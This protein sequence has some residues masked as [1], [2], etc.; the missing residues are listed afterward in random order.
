MAEIIPFRAVRFS[1]EKVRDLSLVVAPPYDVISPKQQERFWRQHPNNVIRLI[2]NNEGPDRYSRAAGYFRRWLKEGVLI[3]DGQPSIYLYQQKYLLTG[4]TEKITRGFIAL[5]KL[6]DPDTGQI[7]ATENIFSKPSADRL[8][9]LK[10]C[11]ANLGL[12]LS[13]YYDP[14]KTVTQL[15]RNKIRERPLSFLVDHEGIEHKLWQ[16]TDS[17]IIKG[18]TEMIRDKTVFIGDGHHRYASALAYRDLR[19]KSGGKQDDNA[20]YVMMYFSNINDRGITIL[21]T[22]RL[23]H[24]LNGYKPRGF[25]EELHKLFKVKEFAFSPQ[26]E[27]KARKRMLRA[28]AQKKRRENAFGL[29]TR[30]KSCYYMLQLKEEEK[31][32]LA[33]RDALQSL[34]VAVLHN[35]VLNRLLN[36]EN[37]NLKVESNIR[38][39]PDPEEAISAVRHGTAQL[40]FILNPTRVEQATEVART[41]GKM[42]Q[43]STYFYPKLLS[44]LVFNKID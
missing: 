23:I 20:D 25:L 6:E 32:S 42:P 18:V 34:D 35:L 3:R 12:I 36:I 5:A 13:I 2:L 16:I 26:G 29:I 24:S 40:A 10:A 38:L 41:G 21:P 44:G 30:G 8:E 19:R 4:K 17:V 39:T 1:Q 28:L 27:G 22:H 37:N 33:S 14:E 43:K 7:R 9:L 31:D 15:T 11:R